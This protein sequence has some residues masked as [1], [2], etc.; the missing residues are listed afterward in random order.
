MSGRYSIDVAG[1]LSTTDTVATAL[2]SLGQ[3]VSDGLAALDR[4]VHVLAN[5]RGLLAALH[6]A[7]DIRRRTGRGAV[8]HGGDV[9]IAAGRI[10][11]AYVQADGEMASTTTAAETAAI[12][13]HTPVVG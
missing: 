3:A 7:T 9:V 6:G 4:V 10:A 1:F 5:E 8:Q 12:L 13:P 2:E 11:L